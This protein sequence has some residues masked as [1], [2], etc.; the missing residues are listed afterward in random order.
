M[1]EQDDYKELRDNR[2]ALTEFFASKGWE[3]Y[4]KWISAQVAADFQKAIRATTAE[5]REEAR[6][7]GLAK[8]KIARLPFYLMEQASADSASEIPPTTE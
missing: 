4:F 7:Q 5:E 2:P 1:T 3:I 8:E 6:V